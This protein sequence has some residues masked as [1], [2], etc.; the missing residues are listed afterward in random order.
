MASKA[1][2][3][4]ADG[5]ESVKATVAAMKDIAKKI[6][7]IDDI[8]AQDEFAGTECCHRSGARQGNMAKICRGGSRGL[9]ARWN[10]ARSPPKKLGKWPTTV[11]DLAETAGKLLEQMV[12]DIRKTAD[13]VQEIVAASSEQSTGVGQPTQRLVA[14]P[15]DPAKRVRLGRSWTA[16]K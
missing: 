15:N 12:P 1:A 5:G 8:V 3:D 2:Q 7:I 16:R 11:F 10:A 14:K 4:A 13:L 6:G 9:Q